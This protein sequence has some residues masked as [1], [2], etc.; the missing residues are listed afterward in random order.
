MPGETTYPVVQ[1]QDGSIDYRYY[2]TRG[3][4]ARNGEM[5]ILLRRLMDKTRLPVQTL[6]TLA[7]VITIG[8]TYH[9]PSA[10]LR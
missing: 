10:S 2:A 4:V 7:A 6:S 3:L 1:L 8:L 9:H 5:K